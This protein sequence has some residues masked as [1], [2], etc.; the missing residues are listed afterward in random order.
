MTLRELFEHKKGIRAKKYN[1]KPKKFIEPIKP[2]KAESPQ[3]T[4][5]PS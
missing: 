4:K 3:T 5:E 1:K 2:K